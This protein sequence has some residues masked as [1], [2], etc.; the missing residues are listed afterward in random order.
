MKRKNFMIILLLICV[1]VLG[2]LY[3]KVL[4]EQAELDSQ[5]ARLTETFQKISASADEIAAQ[6]NTNTALYD[7]ITGASEPYAESTETQEVY[8]PSQKSVS[9]T[10]N[11]EQGQLSP[12]QGE[13]TAVPSAEAAADIDLLKIQLEEQISSM[14]NSNGQWAIYAENLNTNAA[15]SI[16]DQKMQAASLIKLFIMG[17]V[18]ENYDFL[19]QNNGSETIDPSLQNMI[20]VSDNDAANTLVTFL[21]NGDSTQGM[22][23]V[24]DFCT[25]HGY[26]QTHMGRLLLAPNDTDDNYTSVSDC[27]R[28]LASVYRNDGALSHTEDMFNLL[29][30]QERTGKIPAGVPSAD[31][32]QCANKTGELSDVENDAAIIFNAP[33]A[34]YILCIM[35]QELGDPGAARETIIEL[36][37]EIYGYFNE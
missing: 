18:Y 5:F 36:S 29:K 34:D 26:S 15:F 17:S 12:P 2:G 31:G 19:V 7:Q 9:E 22:A 25:N 33:E 10:E 32:A 23:V 3:L 6:A 11:T 1:L 20:T 24:N 4:N 27:G 30:A 8:G 28:F 21:G 35:T 16:Q 14:N 37:R 13:S